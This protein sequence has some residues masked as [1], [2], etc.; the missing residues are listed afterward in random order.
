MTSQLEDCVS[1]INSVGGISEFSGDTRLS[2]FVVDIMLIDA[3]EW[4]KVDCQSLAPMCL[5]HLDSI[6]QGLLERASGG[7]VFSNLA[8]TFKEPLSV[9][10]TEALK[11]CAKG[12]SDLGLLVGGL[13]DVLLFAL[14]P[15]PNLANYSLYECLLLRC[16]ELYDHSWFSELFPRDLN[17]AHA[18][19][20]FTLLKNML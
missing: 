15:S 20:S 1:F 16:D 9:A 11:A 14:D 10:A 17:C 5:K 19:A 13:K 6:L 12:A 8:L 3:K 7:D 2:A 18:H 4:E